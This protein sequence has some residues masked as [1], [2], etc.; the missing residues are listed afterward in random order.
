MS[1]IRYTT[2]FLLLLASF[3]VAAPM[4]EPGL[5][6]IHRDALGVA[7]EPVDIK[8]DGRVWKRQGEEPDWRRD[9]D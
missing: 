5:E 1:L 2:L 3:S 9:V 4:N 8:R 7:R 6:L